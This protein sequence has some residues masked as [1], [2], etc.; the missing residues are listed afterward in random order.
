MGKRIS[1]IVLAF[2]L[3]FTLSAYAEVQNVKVGGDLT[4]LALSRYGF[5]LSEPKSDA[6]G[7][8]T[9][10][11]VRIDADLTDNVGVTL[12][13]LNERPWGSLEEDAQNTDID[14]DLGYVT[15]KE[16]L[17]S[18]LVLII[19]R[20]EIHL[21]SELLIGDVD[22]NQTA[23]V[24]ASA[25]PAGTRDLSARKAFDA[26]VGVLDYS[27]LKLTLGFA[28]GNEGNLTASGDDVNVWVANVD[29]DFGRM[30]TLGQLYYVLVE[31]K[32]QDVNNIGARI[33][34]KP[35]DNLSLSAEFCYQ[36]MRRPSNE[37]KGHRSD[38][39]LIVGANYTFPNVTW[40][41]S[42]GIDYSRLSDNWYVMFENMTPSDI[43]NVLFANTNA[44]VI[45][46]TAT[47]KP[48][49]DLTARLRFANFRLVNEIS[50]FTNEWNS[51]T[52]TN[53]KY[54]G[55]EVDLTL[56]YDYTEDVQ[57]GLSTGVFLPGKAFDKVNRENATQVIGSMK[58]TF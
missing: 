11:R 7:L 52:M 46:L 13:L 1:L 47:T 9:V 27:P 42:L 5:N 18:P 2:V 51:Y 54:L 37:G 58:V 29:Y 56:T 20:Q 43:A 15:L 10:A 21:G 36:S 23:N 17:Y 48:M 25:L 35:I 28:K 22:T 26:I 44:Q 34:S 24:S 49:E 19:G 32:K 38:Y 33:V 8:V 14:L 3:G 41:P 50:S 57:F 53:K 55:N 39:A 45:G 6:G 12:R 30:D 31:R 40:S 4:M 16:F